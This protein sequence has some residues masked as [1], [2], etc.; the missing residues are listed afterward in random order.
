MDL[1]DPM[2]AVIPSL[3]GQV[4]RV[5]A[6]TSHPLTASTVA[7]LVSRGSVPGVRVALRRLTEVGTVLQDQVGRQYEYRANRAHAAWPAIQSA[8]DFAD[9]FS[10]SLDA[11]I[12]RRVTGTA[13]TGG[14]TCAVFGS[15]ARGTAREDSD[16]DLV[17]VVPDDAPPALGE[18]LS[19]RLTEDIASFTGNAVNVLLLSTGQRDEMVARDDGL[20]RSWHAEARTVHGPDLLPALRRR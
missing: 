6:G 3:E 8:V 15:T 13:G 16:V 7:R 9:G 2:S 19:R 10:A 18:E 17:L 11:E 14:V 5:L 4:L 1:S 20:V 12:A